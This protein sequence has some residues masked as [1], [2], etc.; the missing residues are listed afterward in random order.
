MKNL[1]QFKNIY[2]HLFLICYFVGITILSLNVGIT[3]DESHSNWVW[4]LN[5]KKLSNI[6]G[7][8]DYDISYLNTYH[9]Y[10]GV[11]FYF[12]AAPLE[13][14]FSNL[15][16]IK[17]IN[18]EGTT[19]L[20]KH[21][22]VF[23]YF[24]ISGIFF[25]KIIHFIT[26]DKSFSNLS[27][28]LYLTYPYLL[29]HSFFNIKD[30]PFMS[31]WLIN[32]FLI[33]KILNDLFYQDRLKK[34]D[35]LILGIL[36][37][38]LLSLRI[39]GILIFVEYFIFLIFYL[40]NFKISLFKFLKINSKKLI[41][42]LLTSILFTYL[43]YPSF[44]SNPLG[45]LDALNFMGQHIQ[46]VCTLTLGECMKA[47]NLPSSYLFIWMF[48]KLPVLVLFGLF[49]FPII[50][51]KI[52]LKKNNVLIL[53]SLICSVLTIIFLLIFFDVNLYDELRQV[54][55]ILPLIFIISL[56]TIYYLSRK[57]SIILI[58][59]C[60]VFFLFQ[61]FKLFPYNYLWLNNLNIFTE[62]NG[63]FEKDYWGVSTKE[64]ASYFNNKN[65]K[66][67][68]CIISNRND[69]IKYFL[70]DQGVCFKPFSDL[71]KTNKRPFYVVLTERAIDKGIPNK[72]N[73]IHKEVIN[74]NF[75]KEEVVL[76]KIYE[77]Y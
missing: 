39:S 3:H 40:N 6:I 73:L 11:G 67:N 21:P 64:I 5:Q 25:R 8:G 56:V 7:I 77:C 13:I 69:G 45:F 12:V 19:L 66:K 18:Y 71:H 51:K 68:S 58:S 61:N 75:S 55:F 14:I 65:L 30:I 10:Y 48:F 4:K 36:T 47:Q 43:F 31:I 53:G 46:T 26:K 42:F 38:Y 1:F 32:T 50:E 16:K 52:F 35:L 15:I 23:I 9:G 41:L 33:I 70:I 57:I 72:C 63:N 76:A 29:G 60:I 20:F 24:F 2:F 74:I 17:N 34:K 59:L 44:W 22:I 49:L 37:A 27:T 62:V 28:I 54:M